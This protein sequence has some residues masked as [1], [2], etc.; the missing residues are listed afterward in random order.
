[1]M[2][3]KSPLLIP[4]FISISMSLISQ[5][6]VSIIHGPYLQGLTEDEVTIVWTNLPY[7]ISLTN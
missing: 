6:Q 3:A 5:S 1:M 7:F 4:L 2:Y